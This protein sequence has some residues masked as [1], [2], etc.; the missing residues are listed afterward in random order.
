VAQALRL[1][2]RSPENRRPLI[3]ASA[4]FACATAYFP[5]LASEVAGA[6]ELVRKGVAEDGI[7]LPPIGL[8]EDTQPSGTL[9]QAVLAMGKAARL[10]GEGFDGIVVALVPDHVADAGEWRESIRVLAATRLPPRVR[11]AVLVAPYGPLGSVAGV[12]G[13][14]FR[15]DA[16]TVLAFLKERSPEALEHGATLP[17]LLLSAAEAMAAGRPAEA[18]AHY[19]EAR[20]V[21]QADGLAAQEAV[22]LMALGG[23]CL[24]AAVPDLA[25]ESYWSAAVLGEKVEAWALACQAWLGVGGVCLPRGDHAAAMVAYRAAA[26]AAER[27]GMAQIQAEALQ[28][29]RMCT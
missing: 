23:A 2:E 13:V 12:E 16:S 3:V 25:L 18:A 5:A 10:L 21:C 15:C 26:T 1:D 14:H 4:P 7:E 6:Y 29:A 9:A 28:M 19:R 8:D 20:T 11:L 27:A 17:A 22:V 24:A